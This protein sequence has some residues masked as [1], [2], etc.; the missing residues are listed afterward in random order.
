M[1]LT[2]AAKSTISQSHFH[3]WHRQKGQK[4][5]QSQKSEEILLGICRREV[6]KWRMKAHTDCRLISR[7]AWL[8]W[9]TKVEGHAH[10]PLAADVKWQ[11]H[12]MLSMTRARSQG[13]WA[14]WA[15]STSI[16]NLKK[17]SVYKSIY[18]FRFLE[19]VSQ[20]VVKT[21]YHSTWMPPFRQCIIRLFSAF[22]K[23]CQ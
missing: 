18:I 22:F 21:S 15:K 14:H 20:L 19:G 3:N 10:R 1:R 16:V 8:T 5:E 2:D 13:R 4:S 6:R 17:K 12:S 23:R 11:R 7:R 9:K